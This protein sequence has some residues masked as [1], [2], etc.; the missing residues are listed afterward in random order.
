M[1]QPTMELRCTHGNNP[2]ECG[3][4]KCFI[5]AYEA[6][7]RAADRLAH[8]YVYSPAHERY[9]QARG[10]HEKCTVCSAD[11]SYRGADNADAVPQSEGQK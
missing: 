3:F 9:W 7:L 6:A 8:E 10:G 2:I 11:S 4:D 5:P 1:E